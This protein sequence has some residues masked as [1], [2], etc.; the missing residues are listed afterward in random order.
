MESLLPATPPPNIASAQLLRR[1][2]TFRCSYRGTLELDALCRAFLPHLPT[3]PDAAILAVRNLLLCT[4]G[5]LMTWLIERTAPAPAEHAPAAN[6][7]RACFVHRHQPHWQA[8]W[9]P[10]EE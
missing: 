4:E 9:P 8:G 1:E 7:L 5:Q 2:V 10:V 6:L 3:L